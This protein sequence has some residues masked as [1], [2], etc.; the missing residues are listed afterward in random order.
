MLS[1]EYV[2]QEQPMESMN[3]HVEE[4]EQ[5]P[6]SKKQIKKICVLILAA[7]LLFRMCGGKGGKEEYLDNSG[8]KVPVSIIYMSVM[9]SYY[10]YATIS[11]KAINN[12][13]KDIRSITYGITAWDSNKMPVILDDYSDENGYLLICTSSNLAADGMEQKQIDIG[14]KEIRYIQQIV[15]EYEDY[16]GKI[17]KNPAKKIYEKDYAGEKLDADKMSFIEL[18]TES[19]A[20]LQGTLHEG[21][22]DLSDGK[23]A[24]NTVDVDS[25]TYIDD[26]RN[27]R[28]GILVDEDGNPILDIN[29]NPVQDIHIYEICTVDEFQQKFREYDGRPVTLQDCI[30]AYRSG[31]TGIFLGSVFVRIIPTKTLYQ[32]IGNLE[33]IILEGDMGDVSGTFFL[34][35]G[36]TPYMA[37]DSIEVW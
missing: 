16:D 28:D 32:E 15:W 34:N 19:E 25:L 20:Y 17:W 22:I 27:V 33:D 6:K 5:K 35:N 26:G 4:N 10:N 37:V 36:E 24:A 29:G 21:Y 11:F 9:N 2:N 7:I 31:K 18:D 23:N 12:S 3:S 8:E 14:N 1:T 30:L 13:G